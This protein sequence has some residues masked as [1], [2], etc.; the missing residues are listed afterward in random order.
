MG[1]S[2]GG[3]SIYHQITAY[4][5]HGHR[6][7]FQQAILQSPGWIAVDEGQ[8]E[9]TLQQFLGLL[10][11]NTIEEA[12]KLP[13]E[14]LISANAY[15]VA[16]KS[17]YGT[18]TYGPVVDGDFTPDLP[19]R[20]M[21]KGEFDHSV[22][23][24][25]G[26]NTNEGLVFTSPTALSETG[27]SSFIKQVF[28]E[29]RPEVSEYITKVLYPP[30]PHTHTH[31]QRLLRLHQPGAARLPGHLRPGF[32]VQRGLS[33]LG[34]PQQDVR[35]PVQRPARAT[36]TERGVHVLQRA[37]RQRCERDS[38]ARDAGLHH[39]ASRSRLWVPRLRNTASRMAC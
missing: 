17:G 38:C 21:L 25:V 11:V 9:A 31:L 19:S 35:V 34:L 30:P 2:A 16:V 29:I 3:G 24:M 1:I 12:R 6:S 32:R 18:S 5:G 15:Q 4:G 20:L 23:V 22:K 27:Y 14:K 26:H 7:P 10:N 36:R 13:S 33:E 28:P 8:Q 37:G 39:Q